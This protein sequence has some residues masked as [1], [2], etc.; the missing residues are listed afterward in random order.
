MK[1]LPPTGERGWTLIE[2]AVVLAIAA[3]MTGLLL[4]R[5]ATSK[6]GAEGVRCRNNLKNVGLA[7]RIFAT[8]NGGKFPM[9]LSFTNGGTA[10]WLSDPQQLW[11]VFDALSNE[12]AT[13]ILLHCRE[14]SERTPAARWQSSPKALGEPIFNSNQY[15]S[16]FLGL[17]A[18]KSD[19]SSILGGDRNLATNGSVLPAGRLLITTESE[20]RFTPEI[21]QGKGNLLFGDGHVER[22]VDGNL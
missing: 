15:L 21:H 7:F 9:E 20:P 1:R 5:L 12:L 11:R 13:P 3:I 8:D 22:I 4:P 16:Y 6:Q 10:A 18:R 19:S 14:D 17:N 2:V